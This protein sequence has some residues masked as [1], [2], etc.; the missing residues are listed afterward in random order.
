MRVPANSDITLTLCLIPVPA[1]PQLAIVELEL[2]HGSQPATPHL[3]IDVSTDV[4][5]E[6]VQ[7]HMNNF[8]RRACQEFTNDQKQKA[9]NQ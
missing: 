9:Q 8:L 5:Y 4:F 6:R 7:E 1:K 3:R 2:T